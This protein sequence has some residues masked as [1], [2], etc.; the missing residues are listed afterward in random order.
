MLKSL[1]MAI[2]LYYDYVNKS[3]WL[4]GGISKKKLLR[5]AK[6][7]GPGDKVYE[8]YTIR[9]G[10]EIYNIDFKYLTPPA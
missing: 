8:N 5:Y 3:I 2:F 10:H 1:L 9:K 7:Y 4:L 6:Y